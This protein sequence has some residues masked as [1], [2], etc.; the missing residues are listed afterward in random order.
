MHEQG[1]VCIIG[2]GIVGCAVAYALAC[3]NRQVVLIDRDEPG[4]GG[5]S[6]G[7]AGHIASEFVEP[8]PSPQLLFGFWRQLFEL[9]GPLSIPARRLPR[10]VPWIAQFAAA[11]WRQKQNAT[12]VAPLVKASVATLERWLQKLGRAEL[13]RR[14]GFYEVWLRDD[15][16]TLARERGEVMERV[17]IVTTPAP[18]AFMQSVRSAAHV[19]GGCAIWYPDSA[20]VIDPLEVVRAFAAGA[21]GRGAKILRANVSALRAHSSGG[22]SLVAGEHTLTADAAIVCAGPWSASLLEPLGVSAPLESVRGY[23]VELPQQAALADAPIVYD[24]S[25]VIV[26][27]MS[28]RLR[29]STYME[30]LPPQA[31]ADPRKLARLRTKLAEYGY[32]APADGPSWVG[33]RPVLPD[34]MPGIGR[35]PGTSVFYAVGHHLLGLTLAAVTAELMAALIAGRETPYP[36]GAFDLQRFGA[37]RPVGRGNPVSAPA[38]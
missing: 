21:L 17:G 7:N 4:L 38:R 27:P 3:E 10:L 8:L 22:V 16:V 14:N 30:F 6:Y 29:A 28:G 33:A 15:A 24:D 35:V 31:P 19:A 9:G 18:A 12:E 11:A 23:H 20:H 34:Y 2:A 26:T 1:S 32:P 13:L 37:H 5:A 36:I 25:H